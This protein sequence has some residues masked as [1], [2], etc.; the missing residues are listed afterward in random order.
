MRLALVLIYTF[1]DTE[2]P[3]DCAILGLCFE[4]HRAAF[5]VTTEREDAQLK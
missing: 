5:K 2:G 4:R 3:I 1:V